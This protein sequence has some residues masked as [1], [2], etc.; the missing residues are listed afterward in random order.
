MGDEVVR[1]PM[2]VLHEHQ[3]ASYIFP[4]QAA[5]A[6]GALWRYAEVKR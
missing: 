5:R 6:L 3:I 1:Q 4:E 2:A